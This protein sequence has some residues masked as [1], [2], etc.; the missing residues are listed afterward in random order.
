MN[1]YIIKYMYIY[2]YIY[3]Y[4]YTHIHT[5]IHTY[6]MKGQARPPLRARAPP[7]RAAEDPDLPR[8]AHRTRQHHTT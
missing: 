6:T 3:T 1:R 7:R 8:G 4:V 2:I 5:Y